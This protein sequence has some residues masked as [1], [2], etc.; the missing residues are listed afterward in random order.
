MIALRPFQCSIIDDIERAIAS[1]KRRILVVLPTGGGK[2]V[3]A[4][5]LFKRAKGRHQTALFL[6]HRR[7]IITQTSQ[8]LTEHGMPLGVHGVIMAERTHELR[9]MAPIQVASIDT[10]HARGIRNRSMELPPA[11]IVAFDEAH[12]VRGRT[13]ENLVKQYP[14]A[15]LFGFTA[16][17]CR[18]DGKGLGNIFEAMIAGP[19][20][21]ELTVL[22]FLVPTKVYAPIY[23]DI[24]KGVRTEKGDYVISALSARMNTTELVGD[25]VRDWLAHGE[26]RRTVCF[27][28]D[29]A[30]SA[31]VRDAFLHADVRAE[32]LS[33]ETPVAEREAILARLAA[34]ETEVV[35]NCMVLTEG[36]DCPPVSCCVLARPTKQLGLYRQ[37]VGRIL[38]P[39][40]DKA[41]AVILD[42][43]G[44]VYRHGLPSDDIGWTLE[45]DRK[46]RNVTAEARKRGSVHEI[47]RCPEC[48]AIL[49]GPPPCW[50]CGWLPLRRGRDVEFVDGELGLVR[51]GRAQA[52][53]MSHEEQL[54][55]YRELRG[56]LRARGKSEGAA[57]YW[58]RD[59]K[60]FTPPWNWRDYPPLEPS[61]ATASWAKSRI[62]AWAK[63]RQRI[64]GAA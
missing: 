17:P 1:G 9:P 52:A 25:V 56:Y 54:A 32:H 7:E 46:A 14:D 31:H 28:V 49:G 36:W 62:I 26:R 33:G 6:A 59:H 22:G 48:D 30:H 20:V 5:D 23:R 4:A 2:T 42:H 35:S 38:R 8:R 16:T 10:L 47:A 55:F 3:V 21:A 60:G 34:G 41:D 29:V 27:C 58:C 19:Q 12:R 15:I 40:E 45:A 64:G 63:S 50:S 13:R 61:P 43:A 44:A 57:F 11:D 51:S 18:G 53:V 39:F 24:A 37:M